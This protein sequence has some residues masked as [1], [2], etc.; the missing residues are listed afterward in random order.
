MISDNLQYKN[1]LLK[2]VKKNFPKR[3]VEVFFPNDIW[4]ADLIDL[5]SLAPVNDDV[6]Y[7]LLIIDIYSRYIWLFPLQNKE[8]KTVLDYF[9]SF[10]T[11]PNNLWTDLGSEFTNKSFKKWCSDNDINLYHTG[12]E[13]KAVFAERAIRTIKNNIY[14]DMIE[15]NTNRYIDDLINIV[16]TYNFTIHSSLQEIPYDVYNDNQ[17]PKMEFIYTAVGKP[18]FKVNDCVRISRVKSVFEKGYTP[19]WSEE[20]FKIVGIDKRE[21]PIMYQLEDLLGEKVIGKFYE[22]E[23][24]KTELKDYAL[25]EKVLDEKKSKG[26]KLYFVKYRGYPDKFNE[27]ISEEQLEKLK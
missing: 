13:S 22:Q 11:L 21:K 27:W 26:R 6:K 14:G 5:Q 4:S 12:G 24:Q 3:K 19:K 23:L 9:K 2:P 20:V 17:K 25:V 15:Y 16:R 1:E 18:K 7:I 8:S 10:E